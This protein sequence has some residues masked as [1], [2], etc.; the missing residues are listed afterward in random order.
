MTFLLRIA[1]LA[2]AMTLMRLLDASAVCAALWRTKALGL[3]YCKH[4]ATNFE[5]IRKDV[6][7]KQIQDTDH[8]MTAAQ[9]R[10]FTT[11]RICPSWQRLGSRARLALEGKGKRKGARTVTTGTIRQTHAGFCIRSS[12]QTATAKQQW[13]DRTTAGT[14]AAA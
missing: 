7:T 12:V 2:R 5:Q 1:P 6:T 9:R 14:S 8:L 13:H 3:D 10:N 4:N 11:E